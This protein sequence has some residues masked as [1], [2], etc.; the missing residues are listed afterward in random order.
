MM[1]VQLKPMSS[2][3]PLKRLHD[4]GQAVWLDFLARRF[5]SEGGLEKLIE[6]DGLT[7]LTSNPSIFERAIGG[8][9]DYDSAMKA[10]ET[11]GDLDVTV[12]YEKLAIEDIQHA[13]DVLRP[14]YDA[15][16][17]QD[18]YVS[19]EVSPYLAMNAE[20]TIAQARRLWHAVG[21]DNL[22]IK[23]PGT[24]AGLPAI[25]QLIGEGVNI[26][27]TLLFSQHVYEEVAE[28]YLAGVEHLIAQGGD[29][30]KIASVASVFVS[31]IDVAID[32]LI[33]QQLGRTNNIGKRQV[34]VSL[35]GKVAIAN[36]KLA[37][38]RYKRLFAGA[39]WEKLQA[40]GARVQRLLW[41]STSTKNKTYSDVL[42]VEELIAPDTVNTIPPATMD[43]FRDHGKV[44]LSLEENIDQAKQVMVSL[45]QVG[46]SIDAVTVELVDEGVQQFADAFDKLLGAIARKRTG[47]LGAKLNSQTCEL[48]P[49]LQKLVTASLESWRHDGSV[50]RLW[51]GDA[52][53]W[54]GSD[55]AKWLGWLGIVEE[56]HKRIGDLG[57]L[58][59]DIHKQGFTHI[60]LLG[61][62]GSS[63]GPEVF[64]E[65][66]KH[67]DG[68]VD[69][70]VLDSTDPAQIRTIESKID[71]AK[72]LFIVSSKSG[73]TLEPNILKQYFFEC[74]KRAVGTDKAGSRFI[75][76]T[77]P[78]SKLQTIAERDGF[79]HIA[80]G[81]PSIGG[82]Y[83]VLSDFGLVPAVAMGLDVGRL[84]DNTAM[85]VRSCAADVPAADNPGV[86]L[87]TVLGVLGKAG[88][89]KVTIVASPGIADFGAWLE[90]ML[91]E[92]SGKQ[93]KG[94]IPVDTEPLGLP[95]VYGQD[96]VFVYAR[97]SD[98]VDA[99]Q[100]D[101]VAALERAGHPVVRIAVTD[102]YH[103]G[104][105]FFRWEF[106]T[107]VAG[108]ILGINPFNQPDVE[109]SKDKT[110][111]LT[112][113]YE[114]TGKLPP[115]SAFLE[116][117]GLAL[118][119]DD[120]NIKAFGKAKTL[121][122]VLAAHFAR[123]Q[124]GDYCGLL[125]YVERNQR[126]QDALQEIRVL[127]RDSKRVA[128]CLGFGPRFLH[129]TGQA[130]KGGPNT[131]VFVQITCD[132][133]TDLKVP[134][135]KYTFGVVEAAEARG[136]FEVLAERDRRVL[137]VHLSTHVTAGLTTL[138]DAIRRAFA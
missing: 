23:V 54:T 99:K 49:E 98:G 100:D 38:Q 70:L 42:Y 105:E 101:A 129:S 22:M 9:A 132:H 87:G 61:M 18:G 52:S 86:V 79:R 24:K 28:A 126:H 11:Q 63:L 45:E 6:Q 116:E 137:R 133:S 33:E 48:P 62:G 35:C 72:T 5:V 88:R 3:S 130:Y 108:A 111:E 47:N 85:M 91:A 1:N 110:R 12:L 82:R 27:I 112:A 16:K 89:D 138:K 81:V 39:R 50:R 104:Q 14:V 7:G 53:L 20:A 29:A 43:A 21:R 102:R 65:T 8:S 30:S 134:D 124:E 94:L 128:T 83:S 113:A 78:G 92:S 90:Q 15:T 106:A 40:K 96:R 127:I 56:Q 36:A 13:A 58:A 37:Y 73:S 80:F 60:V 25:R 59:G 115:D 121:I 68:C 120:K 10:A 44:R 131:G 103:I 19:L 77:D 34:L 136:D 109:A 71:P 74:V 67:Q 32:G 93:G 95:N 64:A 118:F 123:V 41:A 125:A 46:I 51:A 69:L 31:R 119:A 97:L 107:A 122:E 26:N 135:Q 55:E 66:F 76:V 117:S 4:C 17:R 75:A 84:L 114:Q 2:V 57:D